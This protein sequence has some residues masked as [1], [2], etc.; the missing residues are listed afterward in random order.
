MEFQEIQDKFNFLKSIKKSKNCI[1]CCLITCE[2]LANM[3]WQSKCMKKINTFWKHKNR[4]F[5]LIF[6]RFQ[7]N[8]SFYMWKSHDSF[9]LQQ[10]RWIFKQKLFA[11]KSRGLWR[12]NPFFIA[13][14]KLIR[15]THKTHLLLE[16]KRFF[17]Q[18]VYIFSFDKVSL[19]I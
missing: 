15:W 7:L 9:H 11:F 10:C 14:L 19:T 13:D 4:T 5:S 2:V 3:K 1:K 8:Y 16:K 17:C 6:Y 18:T 12:R